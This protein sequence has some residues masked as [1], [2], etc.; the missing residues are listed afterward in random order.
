MREL[1]RREFP[2]CESSITSKFDELQKCSL[3]KCN[4]SVIS[5]R[6]TSLQLAGIP[7]ESRQGE[8]NFDGCSVS[9]YSSGADFDDSSW[10][11]IRTVFLPSPSG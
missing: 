4:H 2:Q 10:T 7:Y 5:V 1:L 3:N 9:T 11:L 8:I 6:G